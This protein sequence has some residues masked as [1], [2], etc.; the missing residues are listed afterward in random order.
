MNENGQLSKC[1]HLKLEAY[2]SLDQWNDHD[3]RV[4]FPFDAGIVVLLVFIIRSG[5]LPFNPILASLFGIGIIVCWLSLATRSYRRMIHRYCLMKNIEKC[6]G[7]SA[8]RA[9]S[10]FIDSSFLQKH[11]KFVYLRWF[12]GIP[13]LLVFLHRICKC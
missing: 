2:R 6:L 12:I 4:L 13:F 9:I 5:N 11:I 8:H 10:S 3:A 7:F 1:E